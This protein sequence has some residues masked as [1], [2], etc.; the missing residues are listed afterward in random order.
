MSTAWMIYIYAYIQQWKTSWYILHL[1]PAMV[2]MDPV[3]L[4]CILNTVTWGKLEQNTNIAM[5]KRIKI[6]EESG[7]IGNI[8]YNTHVT[9][10]GLWV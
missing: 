9:L 1:P 10:S 8:L 2:D 7:E 3:D 4:A 5:E 6:M